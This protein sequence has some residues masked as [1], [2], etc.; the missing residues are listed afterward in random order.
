MTS[1]KSLNHQSGD[2]L[3]ALL[4]QGIVDEAEENTCNFAFEMLEIPIY[5]RKYC[6]NPNFNLRFAHAAG[7]IEP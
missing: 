3:V 7:I 5:G 1:P 4:E 2:D 6:A